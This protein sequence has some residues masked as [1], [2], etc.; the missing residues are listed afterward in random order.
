[1]GGGEDKLLPSQTTNNAKENHIRTGR[2]KMWRHP[3]EDLLDGMM[4][5]LLK[6]SSWLPP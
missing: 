4:M 2:Q 6:V 1:L 5:N 3:R